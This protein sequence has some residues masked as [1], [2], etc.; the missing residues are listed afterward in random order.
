MTR[1][2]LFLT[3]AFGFLATALAAEPPVR[4]ENTEWCNIWIPEA[5]RTDLPRVLLIGDS[6]CN[7]YHSGVEKELQG[8]CLVAMVATSSALGDPALTEEVKLLL[9]N[10]KFAAVHF[11]IGLHGWDMTE[12]EYRQEFPKLVR[13]IRQAAPEAKP[14]WATS[15][16]CRQPAPNLGQF[17][18]KNER[19]K[20]RN[21]IVAELAAQEHIPVDDLYRLVEN[22]PEYSGGDGVHYNAKGQAVEAAQVAQSIL[23]VLAK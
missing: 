2:L 10:Y 6:I 15:T 13:L 17:G 8:K 4:R 11:N 5:T 23:D 19:V 3:A 14:V 20:E 21:K 16:P 7:G 22:H 9:G 18:E 12:E 1:S